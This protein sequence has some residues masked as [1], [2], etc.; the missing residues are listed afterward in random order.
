MF[1]LFCTPCTY[2]LIPNVENAY[3]VEEGK[4][5]KFRPSIPVCALIPPFFRILTL[6]R[7]LIVPARNL[8][9]MGLQYLWDQTVS[10]DQYVI[11]DTMCG[12]AVPSF[13]ISVCVRKSCIVWRL[14]MR[15]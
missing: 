1:A 10:I 15:V 4:N 5:C 13:Y 11:T 14:C 6:W 9:G 2:V 12:T 7:I 3:S 8:C